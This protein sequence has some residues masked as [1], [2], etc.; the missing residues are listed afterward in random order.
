[1]YVMLEKKIIGLKRDLAEYASLVEN[2]IETSITGLREKNE[3]YLTKVIEVDEPKANDFE[4]EMEESCIALIA[5]FQP[6]AREL[7]TILMVMKMTNDLER[8]AD[9][10]VNIAES[11]IFLIERP[12]VKPLLDI[13]RMADLTIKMLKDAI[14]SFI[15]EE[16]VLAKE[17]CMR[18]NE[19]DS[20]EE[21]VLRELITYMTSDT[22]TIERALH[23]V[24]ITK[25]LERIADLSTNISED[26]I[27][28]VE[29]RVIKHHKV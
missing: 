4:L 2:M 3:S 21:Q 7:R 29:G 14:N 23:L 8:M 11:S 22:S 24:R 10:A 12:V 19:V 26:T 1:M 16:P 25:N 13:P 9:H 5:Q 17:V 28:M 20:L 6:K 15:N 27:F 18:D